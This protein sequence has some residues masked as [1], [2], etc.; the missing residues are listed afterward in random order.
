MSKTKKASKNRAKFR[1]KL[2]RK[3]LKVSRRFLKTLLSKRPGA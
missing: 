1:N 3:Y 2:A